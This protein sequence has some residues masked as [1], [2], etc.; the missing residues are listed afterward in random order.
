MVVIDCPNG[1]KIILDELDYEKAK[2]YK[3]L[4]YKYEYDFAKVFTLSKGKRISISKLV[5]GIS[6]QQSIFHKNNDPFDFRRENIVICKNKSEFAQLAFPR[7]NK[8]SAFN[9]VYW[10]IQCSKWI[11]KVIFNRKII[12]GGYFEEEREAAIVADYLMK[13]FYDNCLKL[14]FPEMTDEELMLEYDK[15]IV[16]Y[17]VSQIDKLAKCHQGIST[18]VEGER[19]SSFVGVYYD[20]KNKWCA[21]ISYCK[22]RYLKYGFN[23]ETEAALAY[24]EMALFYYGEYA[25]LNFPKE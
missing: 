21:R 9:N 19:K 25:R 18:K 17:G 10:S 13:L 24:D 15:V 6:G 16:K 23:T 5:F 3:W 14:N 8:T 22:K 11:A 7:K 1:N 2:E 4:A 12:H 20:L